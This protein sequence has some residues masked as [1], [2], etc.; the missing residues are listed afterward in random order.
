MT[1]VDRSRIDLVRLPDEFIEFVAERHLATL[2]TVRVDG[3]PHVVPV[4]FTF[5][6]ET[7][8]VRVI[9]SEGGQ[10]VRN[11]EAGSRAVVTQVDGARWVSLE[12]SAAILRDPTDVAH[13]ASRYA[14]RYQEPRVNPHRIAIRIDV[15]RIL[16]SASMRPVNLPSNSGEA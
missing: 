16:G 4:G 6:V 14:N 11:I 10:K 7:L 15:D 9:C 12:G 3:S 2:S 8:S 1:R 5:D 13:A